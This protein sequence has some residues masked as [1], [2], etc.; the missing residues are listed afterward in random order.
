MAFTI[1][2]TVNS[3]IIV[4]EFIF[5]ERI[6][7]ILHSHDGP[8]L[9]GIQYRRPDHREISFIKSLDEEYLLFNEEVSG[10]LASYRG[11]RL[12]LFR[13]ADL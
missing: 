8:I 7:H 13:V 1:L 11:L 4:I 3:K 12:K 6:W 10:T 5:A 2:P 9:L